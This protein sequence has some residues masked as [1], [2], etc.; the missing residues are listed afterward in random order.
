MN[1]I[2]MDM[3]V[4]K[5]VFAIGIVLGVANIASAADIFNYTGATGYGPGVGAVP[6]QTV[7]GISVTEAGVWA[8]Y[9]NSGSTV[10]A[11]GAN[12]YG[13]NQAANSHFQTT[14]DALYAG[15]GL[16]VCNPNQQNP[17][18]DI[19][20][21]SCGSPDHQI[22]N[23]FGQDF[24][25]FGFSAA[26]S[27]QSVQVQS[28]GNPTGSGADYIDLSY[29]LLSSTQEAALVGG[30]LSFS[31]ISFTN[32]STAAT[33][34]AHTYSLAGT[35]QYLLIG[36]SVAADYG[37]AADVPDAFKIQDLTV[38]PTAV[39]EPGSV[40]LIG[41]GLLTVAIFGRRRLNKKAIA[42]A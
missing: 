2:I 36:T 12:A 4:S 5:Y 32:L 25:L 16:A 34:S 33:S 39:P 11:N 23:Y 41:S 40:F 8:N 30:T 21:S 31:S 6:S 22:T 24:V 7:G 14:D 13:G 37:N 42:Q 17:A 28:F 27:L 18:V 1:Q 29:A 20:G 35:G 26:V 38:N 19:S 10:V 9:N 3:R 15:A